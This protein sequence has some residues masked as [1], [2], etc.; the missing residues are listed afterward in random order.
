MAEDFI[1]LILNEYESNAGN[2]SPMKVLFI[3]IRKA[4]ASADYVI[5]VYHGGK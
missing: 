5:V 3:D 4:K 1:S 2:C